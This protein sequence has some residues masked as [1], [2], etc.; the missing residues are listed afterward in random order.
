MAKELPY[1]KFEPGAWD[2]GNIQM[3]S[4]ESKGLFIEICSMYWARLGDLPYALALQKLCN[5]NSD[6]LQELINHQIIT[7]SKD[8]ISIYFLD[9]QL[10]EFGILSEKRQKAAQKRWSDASALQ[11]HSKSNAIRE[12]KIREEDKIP[13]VGE[14]LKSWNEWIQFRKELGKS[15]TP[16][17]AK[18][19][20]QFLGGRAG[21]EIIAIINQSITNGW[22]GLF[23]LKTNGSTNNR[24]HTQGTIR[25]ADAVIEQPKEYGEF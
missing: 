11:V 18:K 19:Q 24:R 7:I 8:K 5:G 13:F 22:T 16:S 2:N 14:E 12:E 25:R 1:F 3:C 21:P 17:T 4:R 6:A 10:S 15:I 23:N 9:E 20:I